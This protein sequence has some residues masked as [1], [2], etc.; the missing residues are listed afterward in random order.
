MFNKTNNETPFDQAMAQ[1]KQLAQN[2]QSEVEFIR[3]LI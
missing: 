3:L 1:G 2:Q